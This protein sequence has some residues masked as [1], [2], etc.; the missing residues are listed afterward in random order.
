M[1]VLSVLKDYGWVYDSLMVREL[2]WTTTM[3]KLGAGLKMGM[4][5]SR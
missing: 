3:Y 5:E 1:P 2:G 4:G